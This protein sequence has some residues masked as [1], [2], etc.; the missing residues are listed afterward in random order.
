MKNEKLLFVVINSMT[1]NEKRYFKVFSNRHI[2]G[3]QN[4]YVLLFNIFQKIKLFDEK[5]II[6]SLEE[7]KYS[8]KFIS[9]DMN[10][11]KKMI[12]KSLNE[13][14]SEKTFDIKIKQQLISIEILFYK[15]LYQE[16]LELIKKA[17]KIKLFN[18]SN[19]LMLELLNWQKKCTGYSLGL[20]KA[21]EV[22]S[23]IESCFNQI[24]I[25][26]EITDIYYNSYLHKNNLGKINQ[27]KII[28]DFEKLLNN[29]ALLNVKHLDSVRLT[30]FYNL[31]YSNYYH[32]KRD[33]KNELDYLYKA[34]SCFDINEEYR[35]ENPLDYISISI[36]VIE[37]KKIGPSNDFYFEVQKL[38][39][40]DAILDLQKEVI[41]ERIFLFTNQAELEHFLYVNQ[42]DDAILVLENIFLAIKTSKYNIEPYYYIKIYYLIAS[43]NCVKG[44][45]SSGLKFI[46]IIINEF[47]F[48]DRPIVFV[49]AEFLNIIIHYELKNYDLVIRAIGN[50]KIKYKAKYEFNYFEKKI[51]ETIYKISENPN[52]IKEKTEFQNLY[53]MIKSKF[54][55]EEDD[56]LKNNYFK[57]LMSKTNNLKLY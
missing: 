25:D 33:F 35:F 36:R 23:C 41:Q 55:K 18:E 30:V 57:Y 44:D 32:V 43:I 38:R 24:K 4:K 14:H 53:D 19:Y 56:L 21:I 2:I 45:F 27:E 31:I 26:K 1:M 11:L 50:I 15:G 42:F 52:I 28:S 17:K 37:I 40:F 7:H 16:C 48:T 6:E 49:R 46:N 54:S 13:F 51:L 34:L 3:G 10:Y 20:I 9:S 5:A 8:L 47:K 39:N 29:E 22:N 12:L